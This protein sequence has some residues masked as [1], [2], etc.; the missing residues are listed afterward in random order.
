MSFRKLRVL[1]LRSCAIPVIFLAMFVRPSWHFESSTAFII[2][3]AGYMFLFAGL[4]V[5]MWSILYIGGR[6]SSELVTDGPYSICRN[7]L[8]I[9]TLFIAVGAGLCFENVV[10]LA[11]TVMVILPVHYIVARMEE[12][13]LQAKFPVEYPAYMQSVPRFWPRLGIYRSPPSIMVSTRAIGRVLIDT[14][15]VLM[16]PQLED[17]LEVLHQHGIVPVLW[18]FP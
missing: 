2:E 13:H 14:A 8:Y 16:I 1:L 10:L 5:R 17:L 4:V 3:F 7:P 6:K 12:P 18:V 11:V 9:G 15:A